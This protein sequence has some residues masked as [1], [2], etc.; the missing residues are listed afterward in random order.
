MFKKRTK[1]T[2]YMKSG[3]KITLKF[4]TFNLS[5]LS[6]SG[7]RELTYTGCNKNFSIDLDEVECCVF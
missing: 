5:R 7:G 2:F 3:D 1:A 4:K 6:S